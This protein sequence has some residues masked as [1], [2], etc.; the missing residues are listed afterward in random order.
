ML[1]RVGLLAMELAVVGRDRASTLASEVAEPAALP[2]RDPERRSPRDAPRM[3]GRPVS[4]KLSSICTLLPDCRLL[5]LRLLRC[6]E[7]R[8]ARIG[9]AASDPLHTE[10]EAPRAPSKKLL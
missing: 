10:L 1:G 4:L 6:E 9:R 2:L 7:L 5:R 3:D 8:A